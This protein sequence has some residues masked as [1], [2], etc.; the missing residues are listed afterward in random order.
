MCPPDPV[1]SRREDGSDPLR[2]AHA[3]SRYVSVGGGL[4]QEIKSTGLSDILV[5]TDTSLSKD[6]LN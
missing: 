6:Q 3:S 4:L 1:L 2:A 5:M